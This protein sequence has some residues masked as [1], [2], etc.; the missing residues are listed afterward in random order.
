MSTY[1]TAL[2]TWSTKAPGG[3]VASAHIN[4][5]QSAVAATQGAIG[6]SPAGVYET[7]AARLAGIEA[8]LAAGG[9]GGGGSKV[10]ELLVAATD[11]PAAWKASADYVCDGV[12]DQVQLQAAVDAAGTSWARVVLSPGTFTINGEWVWKHSRRI[13][14]Q[15]RGTHPLGTVIRQA[16]GANLDTMIRVY[17][18][19]GTDSNAHRIHAEHLRLDGNKGNQ[20]GGAGRGIV[21]VTN[22]AW[23]AS[24]Q[25]TEW[26]SL[27]RFNNIDIWYCRG[28]GFYGDGRSENDLFQVYIRECSG[29]GFVPSTDTQM[30]ECIAG[31]NG[32]AG[33]KITQPSNRLVGCKAWWNGQVVAA[34]AGFE[35]NNVRYGGTALAGCEAQDNWGPG[36]FITG[37]TGTVINGVADSNSRSSAGTYPAVDLWEARG[38]IIDVACS[39]RRTTGGPYFQANA[40][41]CRSNSTL[42]RINLSHQYM[43]GTTPGAAIMTA[44]GY[45]TGNRGAVAVVSGTG[46]SWVDV[47]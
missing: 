45:S 28:D 10:P 33:F 6:T 41:R 26:D 25:D 36:F 3:V 17:A 29:N 35:I 42:N 24:P 23:A 1:P 8:A 44:G 12:A 22:P 47:T 38:S 15:G 39:E 19:N 46:G 31:V 43:D 37:S 18:S 40:L 14:G 32:L 16:N 7:V 20:T 27:H 4:A 21:S 2:D 30:V 9:G 13:K 5:L 34:S 11:A